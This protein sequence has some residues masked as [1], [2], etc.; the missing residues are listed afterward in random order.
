MT[1]KTTD[2]KELLKA[3]LV[4]IEQLE[5]RL[6]AAGEVARDPIAII[7]LD[8]RFPGGANDPDA[9]WRL[10]CAGT[11]AISE[12]PADRWRKDEFY[13]PDPDA[14]GKMNT[15]HGG[16]V[17]NV[18]LF[19]PKFFGIAPR[20]AP[21]MDPQQRLLLETSWGA[22]ENAGIAP[23]ALAGTRT[24]VYVGLTTNDYG[25]MQGGRRALDAI[26]AYFG[27]GV[28]HSVAAGRISYVLGMRGP[29]LT[30]DTACSSSL[31]AIHL[32]CQGLRR[33][34][35][36]LALAGGANLM[37]WPEGHII[38]SK[39]HML[40][41]DGRCK[42]FSA[43]ANGYVRSEGCGVVVLK[44]LADA[45]ADRDPIIAVIRGSAV[46]QDGRSSGLTAPNGLAQEEVMR[47]ALED[48][49]VAAGDVLY[50]EAH[51]TGTS[52]GDPI[53]VQSFGAVQAAQR[54][55]GRPLLIGS[56]KTNIGHLEAAA[57]VAGVIKVA[58]AMA[59][60]EIPPH[61]HFDAPNPHIPWGNFAIEV[62]STRRPWP[63][64]RRL[65]G[66]S[67]FGFSGTNAH[68]VMEAAPAPQASVPSLRSAQLLVLSGHTAAA[69]QSA[70]ARTRAALEHTVPAD[71]ADYCF[72]AAA[73]R[74]HFE[75]RLAIVGADTAQM[76]A[77]LDAFT[78]GEPCPALAQGEASLKRAPDVAM[79]FTGQ[80]AQY[81]GMARRLH[82]THAGFRATLQRCDAL[83]PP[84][85]GRSLLSV[86]YPDAG[87]EAEAE[88]L[89][90]RT[91]WAQ[92]AL[93]AV[94]YALAQLWQSWGVHPAVV[95]GHSVGEYVAACVAGVFS[96]EDGL[97]LIAARARLMDALPAG[98]AMVALPLAEDTVA[99]A[100]ARTGGDVTIAAVNSPMQTIVS[101]AAAAVDALVQSLGPQVV[102]S[103]RPLHV[104]HAFHSPLI[105]PMLDEFERVARG[106]T[107]RTPAI[108]LISNVTG[109]IVSGV[110]D[111]KYWRDHTRAAVRFADSVA[112]AKQAGCS[113]FLEVGPHPTLVTLAAT[114][115]LEG[116]RGV[117]SL[118]RGQDDWRQLLGALGGLYVAGVAIDWRA[119]EGEAAR[120]KLHIPTYAFDRQRH[121]LTLLPEAEQ[122]LLPAGRLVHPLL[123][124]RLASPSLQGTVFERAIA[125]G[126][127]VSVAQH[128]IFGRVVVPA[129]A[130]L[131]M[132]LA[133]GREALG[134]ASVEVRDLSILEPLAI[135]DAGRVVQTIVASGEDPEVR[136][137]SRAP[138]DQ[139][140]GA[141]TVHATGR[142]VAAAQVAAQAL[143]DVPRKHIDTADY[144]LRLARTGADYGPAF[145]GLTAIESGSD[146]AVG[147]ITMPELVVGEQPEY[148][149]HPALLDAAFQLFGIVVAPAGEGDGHI[150]LP[151]GVSRCTVRGTPTRSMRCQATARRVNE[152]SF[153]GDVTLSA[154]DGTLLAL[155][156][157]LHFRRT[158]RAALARMQERAVASWLYELDW[159]TLPALEDA[160]ASGRW[161]LLGEDAAATAK[162]AAALAVRGA[163][164]LRGVAGS[165]FTPP[166]GQGM[167]VLRPGHRADLENLLDA[168]RA[169]GALAGVIH[170]AGATTA[171]VDA[172][173]LAAHASAA[174][175]AVLALAQAMAAEPARGAPLTLVTLG[176]QSARGSGSGGIHPGQATVLGFGRV[177][178]N[179]HPD[180]RVKLV[181]IDE[182]TPASL[183]RLALEVTAAARDD[184]QVALRGDARL[185]ARLAAIDIKSAPRLPSGPFA[186][187]ITQRGVLEN[188][189]F[190]PFA[191]QQ[192]GPGEVRIRVE[193]SGLNFRDVLNA[194]GMYPG[195]PGPL[196]GE[197]VGVIDAVGAQVTKFRAGDAV[198]A[199]TPRA[200][201][202]TV[203]TNAQLTWP[204]PAAM[205]IEAAATIPI[206]FQ[207]AWYALHHIGRMRRGERV[208]IHA[209]AGGVGMAAIQVAQLAGAE[210]FATAGSPEKRALLQSMGVQHVM[211]SRSLDFAAQVQAATRG[212][213][214]DIV[215]N[216]LAGEFITR[217][218][219]L[220]REGGRFLELGKTD[221]WNE[222]RARQVNPRAR[223]T[224]V[225]LGDVCLTDPAL[226]ER[227]FGEIMALFEA[228]RL[229]PLPW[230]VWPVD[231][232]QEAFRFMAQA[233]HIGKVVIA[234]APSGASI[235]A[236][237]AYLV[238]GAFGGLGLEV[239]RWLAA[240][241]AGRLVL[242]GRRPPT[243]SVAAALRTIEE[244]GTAVD[245][246]LADVADQAAMAGALAAVDAGA[247]LLRGVVHAA[248]MLDDAP[249]LQLDAAR[250]ASVM[251]AKVSGAWNLHLLTADRALDLF[252]LFASGAGLMG[253]PGQANYA[254]ANTFLDALAWYRR[255]RGL[256]ALS[257]DW[258]PWSQV[259]MA[260][261]LATGI[262]ER[263]EASGL[264]SIA[265][266]QGIAALTLS[267]QLDRPQ[268]AVLPVTDW[269][270]FAR[271]GG[272]VSG[273][274]A[275]L[276]STAATGN[277]ITAA[278]SAGALATQLAATPAV[279]RVLLL[280]EKLELEVRR[281]LGLG[282]ADVIR[283]DRGLMELGMDSLMAV[284]LTNRLKHALGRSLPP[285]LT[286]EHPTIE[287]LG[288]H[289][290]GLLELS[291][292]TTPEPLPDAT[293]GL[294]DDE[295]ERALLSELQRSGY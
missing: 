33:R 276:A 290:L 236:D 271:S 234:Q 85:D 38:A 102:A 141:W 8:C 285:T 5:R 45:L 131:E 247:Q 118:R 72:T 277:A 256:P 244:G 186:V 34:E 173:D 31:V 181:D 50:A 223:Y 144:Y 14:P 143:P 57:G 287:A 154:P 94:E 164:V 255:A 62:A 82:E 198:M 226:V 99:A 113:V 229:V 24:G 152:D 232:V 21:Q 104:S 13:D 222:A 90:K 10:L 112:M 293:A 76:N 188:L 168:A 194:L 176:A 175:L 48:A 4:R 59:H 273:L 66:V 166:D 242:V 155:I 292:A 266:A 135:E 230:R 251:Q 275:E 272:R 41:P 39:G 89:L 52:L 116:V 140:P 279:D 282:T 239:A 195:P 145:R 161:L 183:A 11:D 258:G 148:L 123:G 106:V 254:A 212:E 205:G 237:G 268:V 185:G 65:A 30:V 170:L 103:A 199:L 80:G 111:A 96:L 71:L 231:R 93:F 158:S 110:L 263:W 27:T 253:A 200:F 149:M 221:L 75:H 23:G 260:A 98:G 68:V 7:G 284:E 60:N 20:E 218:L 162:L 220:L 12:I 125:P 216:S 227:M 87:G 47:Q 240:S 150:Y 105:E 67:A 163:T 159:K 142:L 288:T 281:V 91:G 126:T 22:L 201:S 1:D 114:S 146:D 28:A 26:D 252:V 29:C 17:D 64:G 95:M 128:R 74:S 54:A 2:K 130:C 36:S 109:R 83:L 187:D 115:N 235:R 19:D 295:V 58:L 133:A 274:L 156:E 208:L 238:T 44:R 92:P 117:G 132:A 138:E 147:T 250:M 192:P 206:V 81:M 265:P 6:A 139:S 191:P 97:K 264:G 283:P 127:L 190:V 179:E 153:I 193:A 37:L 108:P 73:G 180:L 280:R 207:T 100:L 202:S 134:R 243:A 3:A 86:L 78:S 40:A 182:L 196:G 18:D 15:R 228:G 107:F 174:P 171:A 214:I 213:G 262:R 157:G 101:G 289:L 88:A 225:Y 294:A 278:S 61:L 43:R 178:A 169:G 121:W 257:I 55:P 167:A 203:V 172:A 136:I 79:L 35:A 165:A 77:A 51:G 120:R 211:D 217:S 269:P 197:V 270:T 84:V 209:G 49:G 249:V 56:V 129:A 119:Y 53:E 160:P 259:G 122:S 261:A 189:L 9:F 69:L 219:A 204:R 246:V 210:I 177:L 25:R 215:L 248:G 151:I 241:G 42:T 46:N 70:V 137:V 184:E 32:A 267:L 233:R 286:F 291:A 63:A 16:F 245:V 124:V 224:A